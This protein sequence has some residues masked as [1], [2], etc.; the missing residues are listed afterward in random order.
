MWN[1]VKNHVGEKGL[2][3]GRGSIGR[4]VGVMVRVNV[5]EGRLCTGGRGTREG[6]ALYWQGNLGKGV[7]DGWLEL[8]VGG[9]L[10]EREGERGSCEIKQKI[11]ISVGER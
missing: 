3:T 9:R 10:F 5:R 6:E 2:C 1:S 8:V 7:P 4:C 11:Y